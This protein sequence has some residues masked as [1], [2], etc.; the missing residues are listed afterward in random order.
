MA[1]AALLAGSFSIAAAADPIEGNWR[2]G[3][4]VLLKISA[5]GAA[6]CVDVAEGEYAGK[7]SGQL[8]AAGNNK[9]TGTLKQFS[10]GISF[11]GEATLNG[12][13]MKLVAKKFGVAVKSDTWKRM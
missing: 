1:A 9:Y 7:R 4:N 10:T 5:C 8:K 12:G 2:T 11:T 3:D 13:T 6:F